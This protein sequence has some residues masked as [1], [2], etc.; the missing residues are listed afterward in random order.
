MSRMSLNHKTIIT[1]G[2]FI[3]IICVLCKI[4]PRERIIYRNLY[5]E[6]DENLMR[7]GIDSSSMFKGYDKLAKIDYDSLQT[8]IS[9]AYDA[10][11]DLIWH[12][13][14][15][16]DI[17]DLYLKIK[18]DSVGWSVSGTFRLP[19]NQVMIGNDFSYQLSNDGKILLTIIE[20]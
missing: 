14:L 20:E 10:T 19:P 8:V 6:Y 7:Y 3:C 5:Y 15:V 17:D 1:L 11:K 4:K 16:G 2:V 18:K 12:K 13:D 9:V